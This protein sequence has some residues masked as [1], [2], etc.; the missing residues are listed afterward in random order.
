[1]F[2]AAVI[3]SLVLNLLFVGVVGAIY[4]LRP[5][6]TQF[7]TSY[8]KMT[9][10]QRQVVRDANDTVLRVGLEGQ[11]Q[12]EELLLNQDFRNR[13]GNL[14][15]PEQVQQLLVEATRTAIANQNRRMS[16][17]Q[18]AVERFRMRMGEYRDFESDLST[19]E[20][21]VAA[22]RETLDRERRE[23]ESLQLMNHLNQ[24]VEDINKTDGKYEAIAARVIGLPTIQQ[25]YILRTVSV[26]DARTS[27]EAALPADERASLK[28]FNA[29]LGSA[30]L[31]SLVGSSR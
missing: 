14:E 29:R 4:F 16:E 2:K 18:S 28:A 26:P 15:T 30:D 19:R 10:E 20:A 12:F 17:E 31:G 11:A 7:V 1:M 22:A 3:L 9:P 27:I 24:L 6:D 23:W 5:D 25:A 13:F 8:L 21:A